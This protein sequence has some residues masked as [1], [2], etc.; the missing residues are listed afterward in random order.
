MNSSAVRKRSKSPTSTA[1]A[2]AVRVSIPQAAKAADEVSPPLGLGERCDL[3][4]EHLD[5]AVDQVE[6]VQVGLEGELLGRSLEALGAEPAAA[7]DPPRPGSP[8]IRVAA[9]A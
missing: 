3:S 4:L 9:H 7:G 6:G 2:S 5:A 8:G 1:I